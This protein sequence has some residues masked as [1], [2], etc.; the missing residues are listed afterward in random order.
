[1]KR[2]VVTGASQGIGKAVARRLGDDGWEVINLDL[3]PPAGETGIPWVKADLADALQ[4]EST[5]ADILSSGPVTGLVNNAGIGISSLLEETA[6][7]DF[8]RQVAINMRAPMICARAVVAGMRNGGFGRIVN[9]SSRA[10]LGKTHR[11]AYSGS[12]GAILSMGRTWALELA[13]DGITVNTIAPGPI[14]TELFERINPPDMPRTRE[15]ID[16]VP[17]GRL[18][19]PEDIANAVSFFMGE[20][21][22]FVTGQT[23]YVC[24]GITLARGGN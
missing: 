20:A 7:E 14:R 10:H 1:M 24:G 5:L 2:A 6:D 19:E 15:I 13:R 22:G 16:S 17:V 23:L 4:L 9:I 12:K 8:D 18:G 21:A 3:R 11:T